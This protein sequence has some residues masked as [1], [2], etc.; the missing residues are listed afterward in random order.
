M[1]DLTQERLKEILTYNRNSGVFVWAKVRGACAIGAPAG[2]I[3]HGYIRIGIDGARYMAHRLAWLYVHGE[4]P[5][6]QIDHINGDRSDNRISNLRS[7][8]R[9]ENSKNQQKNS[10]NTSGCM[11]VSH[12]KR[13]KPWMAVMRINGEHICLGVF[14]EWWDAVC[15]RKSGEYI[16]GYHHNHGR[17][18]GTAKRGL[19]DDNSG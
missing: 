3:S 1:R 12:R 9:N 2:A 8:V 17:I 7:V 18:N 5:P 11:G 14:K 19:E 15:A 4:F 13:S 16:N 10:R 6:N